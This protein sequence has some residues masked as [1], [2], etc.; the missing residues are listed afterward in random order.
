MLRDVIGAM[1]LLVAL[2][3]AQCAQSSCRTYSEIT[4]NFHRAV[5]QPIASV[6]IDPTS[7]EP[8][9]VE[10][11]A[12]YGFS[13]GLIVYV[14]GLGSPHA[15]PEHIA[16]HA[17][18]SLDGLGGLSDFQSTTEHCWDWGG[19]RNRPGAPIATFLQDDLG[20]LHIEFQLSEPISPAAL[21]VAHPRLNVYAG[22]CGCEQMVAAVAGL[23]MIA[24]SLVAASLAFASWL[25]W[26]RR[27]SRAE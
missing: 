26:M 18:V 17:N 16:L 5:T 2:L 3:A 9:A 14:E 6:A 7:V 27:P 15:P 10:V 20:M 23:S 4:H 21:Q 1:F 11:D 24:Q 25:T 8:I 22:V 19:G 13:H 12:W